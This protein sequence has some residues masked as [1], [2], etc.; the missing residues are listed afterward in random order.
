MWPCCHLFLLRC[1]CDFQCGKGLK[2]KRDLGLYFPFFQFVGFVPY[3]GIE[4]LWRLPLSD[5]RVQIVHVI[6]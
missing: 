4:S 3:H 6:T 5:N 2:C 1:P